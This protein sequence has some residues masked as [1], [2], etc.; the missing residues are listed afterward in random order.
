VH[1]TAS[2]GALQRGW[3]FTAGW[4]RGPPRH[5]G[6]ADQGNGGAPTSDQAV[7]PPTHTP[8]PFLSSP[9][10][11]Q[12]PASTLCTDYSDIPRRSW[13]LHFRSSLYVYSCTI[14]DS[15]AKY[16]G[17][18]TSHLRILY[19]VPGPAVT[20]SHLLASLLPPPFPSSPL[21]IQPHPCRRDASLI[22]NLS[23]CW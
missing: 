7:N 23:V 5:S 22:V 13:Q 19:Q 21:H 15:I 3:G 11:E 4:P 16:D 20:P 6:V 9:P 2:R 8:T 14:L 18:M 1:S 10:Q 12:E 17:T